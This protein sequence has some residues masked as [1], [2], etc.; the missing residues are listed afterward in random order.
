MYKK[1]VTG[2]TVYT[3]GS[4][5]SLFIKGLLMGGYWVH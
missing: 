3:V 1:A 4:K 5:I 2:Y